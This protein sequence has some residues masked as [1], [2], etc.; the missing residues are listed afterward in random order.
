[1]PRAPPRVINNRD[2]DEDDELESSASESEAEEQELDAEDEDDDAGDVDVAEQEDGEEE[3]QEQE[4]EREQPR[5]KRA[6][7][8]EGPATTS[9]R[10]GG[11]SGAKQGGGRLKL[12]LTAGNDVC[13]VCGKRGHRAGFV[14]ATYL[15]CPNKP[16]YLC[17]Q[18]GHTTATC[19]HRIAPG[20]G[21]GGAAGGGGGGA[22]GGVGG[23]AARRGGLARALMQR[24]CEGGRQALAP[25]RPHVPRYQVEAAI[26]KIH[27][28]RCCTLEFHPTHDS[29]V[30]SGDKKGGIAVWNFDQVHDRTVYDTVHTCLANSIKFLPW[31]GGGGS[32]VVTASSD[33]TAKLLD[34]ETGSWRPLLDLNP[35]GWVQGAPW[36]MVY[37]CDVSAA[38]GGVVVGDSNGCVHLLDPRAKGSVSSLQLHRRGNKVVSVHVHPLQPAFIL[39]AGNDHSARIFDIR[40]LS[41][42]FS[43][44]AANANASASVLPGNGAGGGGGG[45]A[46]AAAAAA[47]AGARLAAGGG[48]GGA[49]GSPAA[50]GRGSLSPSPS[51]AAPASQAAAANSKGKGGGKRGGDADKAAAA[52]AAATAARAELAVMAHPRVVNAAY[53]SPHTGRRILTTCQDNRLR[54]YDYAPYGCAAGPDREVVHSHDFNRYLTPFKAEWDAK[55]PTES[56]CVVGRY[57]SEDFGGVALHPVDVI[58]AA[59]GGLLR[60]LTDTNLTT[61]SPVNKPHP[62][63]DVIISGSSRS[64]YCWTPVPE[65]EQQEGEGTAAAA[66]AAAGAAARAGGA[67]SSRG[68]SGGGGGVG[69]SGGGGGA[70]ASRT[71]VS[72]DADP[73]G[74]AGAG[75]SGKKRKKG[76]GG[77][78]EALPDFD[79][80]D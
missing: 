15:D 42:S 60:Q 36:H 57:I 41:S 12:S 73:G 61:I 63:R 23:G 66:T 3:E 22:A 68:A 14:G 17:K 53:F 10:G 21:A 59:D 19:P 1:M 18:T 43:A 7:G 54:V 71:F 74:K 47:V 40:E 25:R 52:A 46:A 56:V 4:A 34:L 31:L 48:G 33:G 78:E 20:H 24:E 28:R 11:G 44:S 26:L 62:R 45:G 65:E 13:K 29:V 38:L 64:L 27:T 39:T 9:G 80:D 67:G 79:D 5:G 30:V 8:A 75:T 76:A 70:R 51:P 16:C 6:N 69:G 2:D 49:V 35:G 32:H 50:L 37:G 58:S 77:K 72:F 55:D